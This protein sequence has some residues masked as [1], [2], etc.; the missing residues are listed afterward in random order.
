MVNDYRF[1]LADCHALFRDG[2]RGILEG[3]PDLKIIG[4]ASDASELLGLLKQAAPD[5]VLLDI[6][7]PEFRGIK[8]IPEIK[9][10]HPEV[11]ILVMAMHKDRE[12]LHQAI[13][14]GA[15]GYLLKQDAASDLFSAIEIIRQGGVYVPWNVKGPA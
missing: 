7:M 9:E 4:E 5:L 12:Y 14:A 15:D 8:S 3:K 10:I 13:S 11:K 1:I 6:S 2:V